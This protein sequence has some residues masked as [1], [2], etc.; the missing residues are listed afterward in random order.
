M[1]TVRA[2]ARAGDPAACADSVAVARCCA[3]GR[4]SGDA[5]RVATGDR[6]APGPAGSRAAAR[7]TSWRQSAVV[8]HRGAPDGERPV[9]AHGGKGRRNVGAIDPPRRHITRF[10]RGWLRRDARRCRTRSRHDRAH[11]PQRNGGR[12]AD[13]CERRVLRAVERAPILSAGYC[14]DEPRVVGCAVRARTRRALDRD[15]RVARCTPATPRAQSPTSVARARSVPSGFVS[16]TA[17][18]RSGWFTENAIAPSVSRT[19][20][21][22]AAGPWIVSR[23]MPTTSEGWRP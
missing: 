1:G 18:T 12:E 2:G 8:A 22:D 17:A 23:L 5:S 19:E 15:L 21:S 4:R 10:G 7:A 6:T 16:L 13:G 14:D 3:L 11:G 9:P 20:P